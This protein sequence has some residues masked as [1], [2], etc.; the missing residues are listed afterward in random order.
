MNRPQLGTKV[1]RFLAEVGAAVGK[2]TDVL[3]A[4]VL[5]VEGACADTRF[6]QLFAGAT[7]E[8]RRLICELDRRVS[9]LNPGLHHVWRDSFLGYRRREGTDSQRTSERSGIFL[10]VVPR[11]A[12]LRLLL[13]VDPSHYVGRAACRDI[14]ARGHAG[15]G[16]IVVEIHDRSQLDEF[17]ASF[18][19]WLR[20]TPA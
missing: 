17:I 13:P 8:T 20:P 6:D 12:Y 15:V 14:G 2:G 3:L 1:A 9:V 18:D 5:N 10:S 16:R 4:D 11:K 7:A 19:D